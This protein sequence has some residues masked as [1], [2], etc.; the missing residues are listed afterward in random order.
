ML[1]LDRGP[2]LHIRDVHDLLD[3]SEGQPREL[4]VRLWEVLENRRRPGRRRFLCLF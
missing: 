3:L 4:G 1:A 2:D